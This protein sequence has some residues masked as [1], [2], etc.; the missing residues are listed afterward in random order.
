M[1]LVSSDKPLRFKEMQ[2]GKA[3]TPPSPKAGLSVH[4][5]IG[6]SATEPV[7]G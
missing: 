7:N 5:L 3:G 1:T 2:R 6:L 4:R